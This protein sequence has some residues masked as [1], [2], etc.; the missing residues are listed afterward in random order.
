MSEREREQVNI[1]ERDLRDSASKII[2]V[3]GHSLSVAVGARDKER[4]HSIRW[5]ECAEVRE[6]AALVRVD[7]HQL[8]GSPFCLINVGPIK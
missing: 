5:V 6:R 2:R 3:R 4:A 1:R 8:F 7:V